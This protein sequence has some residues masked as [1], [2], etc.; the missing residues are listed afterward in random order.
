MVAPFFSHQR[1]PIFQFRFL[2]CWTMDAL[3]RL[4]GGAVADFHRQRFHHQS[5][6]MF[7]RPFYQIKKND[8]FNLAS[9]ILF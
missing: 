4:I 9:N 5:A 8:I 7:Q 1:V 2:Q 3:D 6:E